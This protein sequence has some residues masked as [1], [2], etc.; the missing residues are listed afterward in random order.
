MEP[1]K[2]ASLSPLE[3][4]VAVLCLLYG[5]LLTVWMLITPGQSSFNIVVGALALV[6]FLAS[7]TL[8]RGDRT[9][10]SACQYTIALC[11]LLIC[12]LLLGILSLCG[13]KDAP[14]YGNVLLG[15]IGAA[16]LT[17]LHL[18]CARHIRQRN[19]G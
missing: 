14:G 19:E 13:D 5:G 6:S 8:L 2:R 18:V 7:F 16:M 17:A 9:L 11:W 1:P 10:A 3:W 4:I 15:G 12:V